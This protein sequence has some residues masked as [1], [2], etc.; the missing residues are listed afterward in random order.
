MRALH[1]APARLTAETMPRA[2]GSLG[3]GRNSLCV[4]AQSGKRGNCPNR[5]ELQMKSQL[6][7]RGRIFEGRIW[8]V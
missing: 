5:L 7:R 6:L 4:A 2:R 3:R 1:A 8:L